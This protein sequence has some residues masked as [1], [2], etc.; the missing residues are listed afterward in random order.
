MKCLGTWDAGRGTNEMFFALYNIEADE[1][2]CGVS[3][4]EVPITVV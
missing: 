4:V 1:Y 3:G 2:R